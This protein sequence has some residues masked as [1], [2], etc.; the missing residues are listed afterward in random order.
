M[1]ATVAAITSEESAAEHPIALAV[2]DLAGATSPLE[3][4]TAL[5]AAGNTPEAK[6]YRQ[7]IHELGVAVLGDLCRAVGVAS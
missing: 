2:M 1:I 7:A 4:N 3:P 5:L 6:R